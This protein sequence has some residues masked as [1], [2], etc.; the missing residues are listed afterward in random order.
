MGVDEATAWSGDQF[1]WSLSPKSLNRSS[2][3]IDSCD[4]SKWAVGP[5]FGEGCDNKLWCWPWNL[6]LNS[7]CWFSLSRNSGSNAVVRW[8]SIVIG[9]INVVASSSSLAA[10]ALIQWYISILR[11]CS[12]W[13]LYKVHG[14][15][16]RKLWVEPRNSTWS[17]TTT[18]TFSFLTYPPH[19]T[20]IS[21]SNDNRSTVPKS[22]TDTAIRSCLASGLLQS[23]GV[24]TTQIVS[25]LSS[26]KVCNIAMSFFHNTYKKFPITCVLGAVCNTTPTP[27]TCISIT[28]LTHP[29]PAFS[30][31]VVVFVKYYHAVDSA[32]RV[33]V[34]VLVLEFCSVLLT[35]LY[36][37]LSGLPWLL[38]PLL[39]F[40]VSCHA[41]V[42]SRI[43]SGRWPPVA[44]IRW[45]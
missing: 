9:G 33:W 34:W 26:N 3:V 2:S 24:K 28:T 27:N 4:W 19:R 43:K 30:S 11:S 38:D 29:Y 23:L 21:F 41:D 36:L 35:M 32:R 20:T 8:L 22:V 42:I 25:V 40:F 44:V 16:R 1:H 14:R 12:M 39:S 15:R 5:R 10:N 18:T 7:C 6:V 45:Q 31:L 13:N 37:T 17:I